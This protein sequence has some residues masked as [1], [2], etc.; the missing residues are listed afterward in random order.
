MTDGDSLNSGGCA[1]PKDAP[2]RPSADGVI[3][4]INEIRAN[5]TLSTFAKSIGVHKETLRRVLKMGQSPRLDVLLAVCRQRDINANW[6]LL[7][8]EPKHRKD[9]PVEPLEI[10]GTQTTV[11]EDDERPRS[12]RGGHQRSSPTRRVRQS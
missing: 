11:G 3:A 1:G 2:P 9:P 4:R 6:L 12:P 5:E 7:G 10:P 8:I